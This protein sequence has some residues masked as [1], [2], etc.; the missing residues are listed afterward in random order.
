M[1]DSFNNSGGVLGSIAAQRLRDSKVLGVLD[2]LAS[3]RGSA[4]VR[5]PLPR[6]N[7][8]N[9]MRSP[10]LSSPMPE[11]LN[12]QDIDRVVYKPS[13]GGGGVPNPTLPVERYNPD[14]GRSMPSERRGMM[15]LPGRPDG[16]G[17]PESLRLDPTNF[18]MD[19]LNRE[20]MN[21]DDFYRSLGRWP[22]QLDKMIMNTRRDWFVRNGVNPT[23]DELMYAVNQGMLGY[24]DSQLGGN[25]L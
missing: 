9:S 22:T 8:E 4:F 21:D 6:P 19:L 3:G 12:R 13:R 25:R 11:T 15:E 7:G 16:F 5:P 2:T 23:R 10:S 1:P 17:S 18:R 24:R 20:L 14:N